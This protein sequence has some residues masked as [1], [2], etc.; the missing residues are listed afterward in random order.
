MTGIRAADHL[1]DLLVAQGTSHIFGVPGESY[2]P[3]LDA[4]YGREG[5]IRF[6]T[7][8]Q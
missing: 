8:R 5:E 7:S 6:I 4:L 2:L 1:V 3:V